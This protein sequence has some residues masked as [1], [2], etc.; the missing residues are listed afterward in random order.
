MA[1]GRFRSPVRRSGTRCL[2]SSEIWHVVLTFL[3]SFLRQS[4][5]VFTNVTSALDVFLNDMRYINP[6]F[7]CLLTYV[8]VVQKI[9]RCR[10]NAV[11]AARR[12]RAR[13]IGSRD[14][15]VRVRM[16]DDKLL[17][18]CLTSGRPRPKVTWL[19]DGHPLPRQ[20]GK[21]TRHSVPR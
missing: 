6:R 1:V 11:R 12:A 17:L 10:C 20:V 2:T 3:S 19:K 21:V 4:C 5:S 14:Q 18:H 15:Q 16:T 13:L 9:S 8:N 7:T